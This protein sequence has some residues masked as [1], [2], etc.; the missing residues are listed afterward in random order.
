VRALAKLQAGASLAAAPPGQRVCIVHTAHAVPRAAGGSGRADPYRERL[1]GTTNGSGS[2]TGA[3]RDRR[4]DRSQSR[5]GLV[6]DRRRWYLWPGT[7]P[8][9]LA[10]LPGRPDRAAA[11]AGPRSRPRPAARLGD[12]R[13]GSRRCRRATWQYRARVIV[14]APAAHVRNR[15]PIPVEVDSLG[16]DRC[17][18][19]PG[20]DHP[21]NAR[22][23]PGN[24]GRGLHHRG[25]ARPGGRA[26]AR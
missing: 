25:L 12:R 3:F 19:E 17:A 1:P 22:P 11:A 9:R 4:A 16:D 7:R 6:N 24:A 13:A 5:T 26:G 20:S 14:H 15:L 8:G 18:F 10:H 23:L 2:T 21:G